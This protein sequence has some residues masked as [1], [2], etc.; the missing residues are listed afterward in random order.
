MPYIT[1]KNYDAKKSLVTFFLVLCSVSFIACV[2][3]QSTTPSSP[4]FTRLLDSADNLY[5][6]NRART[7]HL[8]DSA[9]T[10]TKNSDVVD[11]FR[12]YSFLYYI[13]YR[14]KKNPGKAMLYADSML[15]TI[16]STHNEK[17]YAKLYGVAS[18]AKGDALFINNK[19]QAAYQL[20]YK[21]NLIGKNYVD[22]CTIGDYSYR[23]GMIMY[24]QEHFALAASHFKQSFIE[25]ASCGVGFLSYYRGQE[26]LDNAALSYNK[27]GIRDSAELYFKNALSYINA[28]ARKYPE[29]SEVIEAARGVVYGNLADLYLAS[30]EFN[31]AENL[32]KKSIQINLKKGYENK[33]AQLTE[34]KLARLYADLYNTKALIALLKNIR[35][36]LD[37]LKNS[38]AEADWNHL[39]AEYYQNEK[40]PEK[41]ITYLFKYE[42]IKD[43][44]TTATIK[45][46]E[47]N[48]NQQFKDFENQ[49]TINTLKSDN[50]TQH[51]Y[52]IIT[53]AFALMALAIVF[54]VLYNWRRSKQNV[55]LLSELNRTVNEQ[56][57]QLETSLL[58]LEYS[59]KEKDRILRAVSHDL[60]NP[61]GGI[62]SLT[63]LLLVEQ[64]LDN[65]QIELLKLIQETADN[66][67]ELINEILEATG[68][69]TSSIITRQYVDINMLLS[70][71]VDLLRF[72]AAEKNQKIM[73][74]VLD[75]P[76]ELYISREKI[77]RVLSNLI[78][79]AIKFSPQG[80][81]IGVKLSVEDDK[82][83]IAVKDQGIGIPADIKDQV[84]NMF[85]EA[86][87]PGTAGEKSF[88]LGLS[89]SKQITESHNGEI[90]F[91]STPGEGTTFYVRLKKLMA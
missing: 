62:A 34:L 8:L 39:M 1:G 26:L 37:T 75:K 74:E 90:W 31:K 41:A 73:L 84:F 13:N 82:I 21:G 50:Q 88:G 58:E 70:H 47:S 87:R 59:S 23:M 22:N 24:R 33:D 12:Y 5:A 38:E 36:Q 81:V 2:Q 10:A 79:N 91:E 69:L 6:N 46:K 20:Y 54:L 30:K 17:K 60:R 48:V 83:K 15:S 86:K 77:W 53:L 28:S 11:V 49:S 18:F 25:N 61:I 19:F 89:I 57:R 51:T 3:K 40:E 52:L 65:E 29:K 85:T 4:K 55:A 35:A 9:K 14:G 76:E 44:L 67:L 56:K 16:E 7:L 72:K 71:S 42:A 68:V 78:S 45:I 80:S 27:A 63:T 32:L 66:S 64:G 43:S